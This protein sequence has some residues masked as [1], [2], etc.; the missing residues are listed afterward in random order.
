MELFIP[1]PSAIFLLLISSFTDI[2]VSALHEHGE[3]ICIQNHRENIRKCVPS[4]CSVTL[5]FIFKV[6]YGHKRNFNN[7]FL[8]DKMFVVKGF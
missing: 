4:N 5:R 2:F 7:S 3:Q 8:C 6:M 1:L